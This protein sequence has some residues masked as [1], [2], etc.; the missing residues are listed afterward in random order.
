MMALLPVLLFFLWS[1]VFAI[2]KAT[3]AFA[4]P[5]FL[6]GFRMSIAGLLLIIYLALAKR[7][8]FKITGKQFFSL[9]L[10]A[11]TS[12][13]FTNILEFWGLQHLS[14]AKTCFIYSLS[15]FFTALL[16][17]FHFG[18]KM[19]P[20]KWLG[21]SIGFL[22]MLPVLLLQP[23][24]DTLF[25]GFSWPELAIIGAAFCAVYGWV[26]L[27]L[28]VKDANQA[29]SPLM[30]NGTSMLLGGLLALIH[31]AFVDSWN[32]T[33]IAPGKLQPF[34]IG[35]LSITLISN[36]ICYNLYGALLKRFTATF[37]S[38]VGL[39]SPIFATL[40]GW[41]FLKEAPRWEIPLSTAIICLGLYLV[42]QAE[43][44]QGYILKKPPA[45]PPK[46]GEI[47]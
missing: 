47:N 14:A 32:P 13:Y 28:I 5:I 45:T 38:F 1:S 3:L 42:Y 24:S 15:P 43:L 9:C 39:L 25:K 46:E 44:K 26:L 21:I 29:V 30:A 22:G 27:R 7:E 4:P 8:S 20:R 31:S 17:Y 36:I 11:L 40:H 2:G 18:E 16:S 34:L 41:I 12:I 19:N 33:P 35:T 6:T 37:L 23:G 10:L